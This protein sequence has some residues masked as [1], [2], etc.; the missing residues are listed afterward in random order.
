MLSILKSAAEGLKRSLN[1]YVDVL[2]DD[3]KSFHPKGNP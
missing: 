2:S 1:N 3:T